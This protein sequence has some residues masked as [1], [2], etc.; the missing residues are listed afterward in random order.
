MDYSISLKYVM[1]G[2]VWVAQSVKRLTL[3]FGSSHDCTVREFEPHV[4]LHAVAWSLLPILCLPLSLLLPHSY[5]L[6]LSKSINQSIN[7]STNNL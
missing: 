7:Q 4:G 3:G 5:S 2:G 1:Q 6:S